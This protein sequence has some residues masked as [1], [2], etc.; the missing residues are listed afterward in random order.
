V[1]DDTPR[2]GRLRSSRTAVRAAR[3]V[4][5]RGRSGPVDELPIARAVRTEGFL[6]V[7]AA[8]ECAR[9]EVADEQQAPSRRASGTG[10]AGDA[11]RPR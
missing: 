4:G 11:L 2:P 5:V 3:R 1:T 9:A 8:D 7:R 6:E 10:P